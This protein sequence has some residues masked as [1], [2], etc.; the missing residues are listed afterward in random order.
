[1]ADANCHT[2]GC[3]FTGTNSQ[4]N[5]VAGPCTGTAGYMADAEIKDIMNN[6]SRVVQNYLD[7]GSN[8]NVLVYDN[9]QWGGWVDSDTKAARK[10]L[11]QSLN[12][13]GTT[14]WATDLQ[15]Y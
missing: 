2:E 8:T 1:M 10:S 13:G 15:S 3:L 11:Y 14:D 5:A 4:S 12:M 6:S 7:E 9:D